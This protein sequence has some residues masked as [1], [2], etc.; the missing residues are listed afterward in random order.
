MAESLPGGCDSDT[1]FHNTQLWFSGG[2][3]N[4]NNE[5]E[6]AECS[7]GWLYNKKAPD[8]LSTAIWILSQHVH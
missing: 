7:N 8:P 2:L 1:M 3:L 5:G 6:I 4:F